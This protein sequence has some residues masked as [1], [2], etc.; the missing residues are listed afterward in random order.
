MADQLRVTPGRL[1]FGTMRLG[2]VE[3]SIEDWVAFFQD[4]HAM[5]ITSLHSSSEYDTFPLLCEILRELAKADNSPKFRHVVKLAEP[6]FDDSGFDAARLEAKVAGYSAA[7]GVDCVDDVQWMWRHN[8]ADDGERIETFKRNLPA[9]TDAV[10]SLKSQGK[11][12]RFFCFPYSSAFANEALRAAAIDGLTVYR[13][14]QETEYDAAIA[15]CAEL[16]KPVLVIRPLNAG[17]VLDQS[18]M[19]AAENVRYSLNLPAI[20]AGIISSNKLDHIRELL[21]S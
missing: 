3:R 19:S 11:I 21:V 8:L 2:E 6:S 9:L 18:A 17:K 7:F 1:I 4:V 20:A 10:E 14:A 5:G 15:D 13:N 12:G 16:G